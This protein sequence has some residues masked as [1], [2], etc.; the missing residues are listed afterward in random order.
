MKVA[1]ALRSKGGIEC[2]SGVLGGER[3]ELFRAKDFV[4]WVQAHPEKCA[5]AAT[6][7]G[8]SACRLSFGCPLRL[9]ALRQHAHVQA[10]A[11][12]W[13]ASSSPK[14]WGSSSSAAAWRCKSTA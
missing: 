3:V 7:E 5:P 10:Q 4:R 8:A 14:T 6:G 9:C 2:R 11:S 12:R 1:E 13:R